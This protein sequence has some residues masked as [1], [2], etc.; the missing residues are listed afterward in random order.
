MHSVAKIF[1]FPIRIYLRKT[2]R[3]IN[4]RPH[5]KPVFASQITVAIVMKTMYSGKYS[6]SRSVDK[7]GHIKIKIEKRLHKLYSFYRK[8]YS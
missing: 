6:L 3:T 5:A 8:E 2:N 7:E 1:F 4:I